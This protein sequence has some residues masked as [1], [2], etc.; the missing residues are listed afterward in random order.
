MFRDQ[1]ETTVRKHRQVTKTNYVA[2]SSTLLLGSSNTGGT[3]EEM[4]TLRE[5]C[6]PAKDATMLPLSPLSSPK[7][8]SISRIQLDIPCSEQSLSLFFH[9]YVCQGDDE[10]PGMNDFLPLFYQQVQPDSCLKH[11]VTATAYASL[12]N[13]SKSTAIGQRAWESYGKALSAV[14]AA[15][16]DPVESLKDETL[17]A[18]FILDCSRT[19]ADNNYT[20]LDPMDVVWIAYCN[21][22]ASRASPVLMDSIYRKPYAL[23][24]K[25]KISH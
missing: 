25:F 21:Y 16:A 17:S 18:L 23:I 11:C 15:L 3:L 10:T 1:T 4:R 9:Q 22:A 8:P 5:S 13:Q 19:L 6:A 14:N 12:A 24:S 20:Y 2:S 7:M